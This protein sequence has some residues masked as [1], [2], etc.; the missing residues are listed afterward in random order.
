[1]S[2]TP[3]A[4]QFAN[5]AL[6]GMM[7]SGKST[8]GRGLAARLGWEFADTD[9]MIEAREGRSIPEIFATD[10]PGYFRE[11][12]TEVLEDVVAGE[13]QVIATG[14]GIILLPRNREVLLSRCWVAWLQATPE[15]HYSRVSNSE[16]RP[17]LE[18]YDDPVQAAADILERRR[19]YY[20]IA[21]LQQPTSGLS[22]E[23][24]VDAVRAAWERAGDSASG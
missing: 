15:E 6:I 3:D 19:P 14:G 12:E 23:Q 4:R 18:G 11:K 10:G 13:R 24:V 17:L 2:A 1:M 5:V 7:G 8:V 16:R 9:S 20:E 22:V 21:D